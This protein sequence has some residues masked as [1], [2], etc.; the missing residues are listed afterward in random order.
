[1]AGASPCDSKS[2]FRSQKKCL[3]ESIHQGMRYL[4]EHL[5]PH[6]H[7]ILATRTDPP[8]PLARLRAQGQLCELRA[9]ELRFGT[10]EARAFLEMVMGLHLPPEAI[11]TLQSRTE[12]WIVGLQLAALSLQG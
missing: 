7:L 10:D 4:V 11:A 5:P 6:M 8:L 3:G 1:M 9:A 12:G 2:F